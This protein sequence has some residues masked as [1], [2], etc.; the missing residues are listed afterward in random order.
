MKE[1]M[2]TVLILSVIFILIPI[3]PLLVS[4]PSPYFTV[5]GEGFCL[6]ERIV[7]LGPAITEELYL[8]EVQDKLVGCT[9][10]CQT[11]PQAKLK[12]KVGTVREVD[13]EKIASL[14]PDLLLA[15]TVTNHNDIE[16]MKRLKIKVVIL[17]TPKNFSQ[18]CEHFFELGKI[19]GREKAAM[20]IVKR[21]TTKA[22]LIKAKVNRLPKP[23]VFVQT[24][25][26]P[27]YT[28][29]KGSF[30]HDY[31]VRAGGINIAASS[32]GGFDYGIYS[33]E[34]VIK[35]N[36]DVI[37]IVT[38]G[39]VGEQEKDIW[40]KFRSINAVSNKRIHII[41][42]HRACSPTPISFAEML[43]E[44]AVLL[45]PNMQEHQSPEHYHDKK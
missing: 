17:P 43:E 45:H 23:R 34:Q 19:V 42:S 33:R 32:S 12:E 27:L 37:L 24:G 22:N 8:L 9:I 15:T 39:I 25:A 6:P 26:R 28:S 11:P 2:G 5:S 13:V 4:E 14:K 16:K 36:P 40:E 35:E 41:D 21:A 20:D 18:I 31:I 44:I 1:S 7:S 3:R 29:N 30:V 38:M 10:Y